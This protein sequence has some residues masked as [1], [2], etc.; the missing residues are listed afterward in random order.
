MESPVKLRL[1]GVN[2][3]AAFRAPSKRRAALART[4]LCEP[5]LEEEPV[6]AVKCEIDTDS[7]ESEASLLWATEDGPS[8]DTI[9][10]FRLWCSDAPLQPSP[11]DSR[12]GG[13]DMARVAA[14]LQAA[15]LAAYTQAF[16]DLGYDDVCF[17]CSE[18]SGE[19]LAEVAEEAAMEPG[20]ARRFVRRFGEGAT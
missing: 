14:A 4:R 20:D 9:G 5:E 1:K 3:T 18:L 13:R 6:F 10:G 19:E 16:E 7:C 2:S 11:A 15:G 12:G 17:L 8:L